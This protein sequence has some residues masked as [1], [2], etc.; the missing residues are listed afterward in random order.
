MAIMKPDTGISYRSFKNQRGTTCYGYT[1]RQC[2][3]DPGSFA[4]IHLRTKDACAHLATCPK[5]KARVSTHVSAPAVDVPERTLADKAISAKTTISY[6]NRGRGRTAFFCTVCHYQSPL[7]QTAYARTRDA[8]AHKEACATRIR[9]SIVC[10]NYPDCDQEHAGGAGGVPVHPPVGARVSG[11][12]PIPGYALTKEQ[13]HLVEGLKKP[14]SDPGRK[15]LAELLEGAQ[16]PE[17]GGVRGFL[18]SLSQ[19]P[20]VSVS[21]NVVTVSGDTSA[22]VAHLAKA[23]QKDVDPFSTGDVIRWRDR[24]SGVSYGMAALK[25]RNVWWFTGSGRLYGTVKATYPEL[26]QILSTETVSDIQVSETW[27]PIS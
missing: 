12:Q 25:A 22:K 2:G 7:Y 26:A 27:A 24:R 11:D 23:V 15:S 17:M 16:T 21:G 20:G 13:E 14:F 1:C 5:T 18:A 4:G 10:L 6:Q 9:E 19:I 3:Y 8:V